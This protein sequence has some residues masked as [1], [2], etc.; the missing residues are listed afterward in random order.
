MLSAEIAKTKANAILYTVLNVRMPKCFVNY[1]LLQ[2]IKQRASSFGWCSRTIVMS[3]HFLCRPIIRYIVYSF[4][5]IV[6]RPRTNCSSSCSSSSSSSRRSSSIRGAQH[7]WE[8]K[9]FTKRRRSAVTKNSLAIID[10]AIKIR[11]GPSIRILEYSSMKLDSSNILVL[12]HS[13]IGR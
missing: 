12:E 3:Y 7:C 5:Q 2:S 10:D 1:P 13:H 4:V 11:A 9:R 6:Y 8:H